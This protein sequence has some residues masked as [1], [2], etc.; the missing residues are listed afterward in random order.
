MVD[1]E[2]WMILILL[3]GIA[4]VAMYIKKERRK[5]ICQPGY[6]FLM[7]MGIRLWIIQKA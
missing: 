7:Q 2:D 3:V 4:V 1:V 6:R 5:K